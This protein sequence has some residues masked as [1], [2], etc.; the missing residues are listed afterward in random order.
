MH[1]DGA[2]RAAVSDEPSAGAE[3]G[4]S[5]ALVT[6]GCAAAVIGGA[7]LGFSAYSQLL[8]AVV[9]FQGAT[10]G[11]D[12]MPGGAA[13]AGI[14]MGGLVA[15]EGSARSLLRVVVD[16]VVPM[17]RE[18]AIAVGI[19]A[20]VFPPFFF[21]YVSWWGLAGEVEL[22]MPLEL[23]TLALAQIVL[24]AIPEEAYFRGYLQ[25]RLEDVFPTTRTFGR[26][27]LRPIPLVLQAAA[28]ALLHFVVEPSPAR[29]AVFFPGLVFGVL[30]SARGG[31][32]AA[33][34][35]HVLCNLYSETLA[36]SVR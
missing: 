2:N 11:A 30:R 3:V 7:R 23:T 21:G 5:Y 16:G 20:L 13:R 28:F 22:R 14:A 27:V 8:V 18:L 12:R 31:I 34:F 10:Y 6:L 9:L 35:F 25:T 36:M 15:E 33:V 24:V 19:S 1:E 29:L 4:R 17:L 26:L 32:G